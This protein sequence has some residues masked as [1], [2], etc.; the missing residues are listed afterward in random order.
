MPLR[1]PRLRPPGVKPWTRIGP[2]GPFRGRLGLQWV[3]APLVVG[4]V[5]LVFGMYFFLRP[6]PPSGSFVS[7]GRSSAFPEGSARRVGPPGV[8][9]DRA[10]GQLFAVR[11]EGSCTLTFCGRRL[12]DCRGAV[13]GL[14]GVAPNGAGALDLLPVRVYRG[15]VYVDPDHPIVGS[16]APAPTVPA[17]SCS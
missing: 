14:D 3:I 5:L 12:A 1:R 4:V 9:V 11:Q 8:F 6:H 2:L 15:I 13:Y 10:G 7:V 16:P 17:A